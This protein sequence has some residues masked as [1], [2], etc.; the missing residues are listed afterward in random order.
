MPNVNARIRG[1]YANVKKTGA[2]GDGL[3]AEVR[4]K[5]ENDKGDRPTGLQTRI[6]RM[7]TRAPARTGLPPRSETDRP[8]TG[9][10]FAF[11]PSEQKKAIQAPGER[12]DHRNAGQIGQKARQNQQQSAAKHA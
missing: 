2:C 5:L 7:R 1:C 3:R 4:R 12:N 11:Q 6:T 9:A 10:D 8:L